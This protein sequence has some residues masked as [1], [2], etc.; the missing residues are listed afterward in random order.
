M[1]HDWH[2][3]HHDKKFSSDSKSSRVKMSAIWAAVPKYFQS[4]VN[5]MFSRPQVQ[6]RKQEKIIYS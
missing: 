4:A 6:E 5:S 1:Q 2:L 3:L